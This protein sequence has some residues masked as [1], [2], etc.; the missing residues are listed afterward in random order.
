MLLRAELRA[1][2]DCRRALADFDTVLAQAPSASLDER[3]LFGRAGCRLRE[4][5][6][7]GAESDLRTYLARY[8]AGRFADQA[9]ARLA[10]RP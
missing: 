2:A 6:G 7:P 10:R 1:D 3:A 4:G 8:P 5:D 9:R